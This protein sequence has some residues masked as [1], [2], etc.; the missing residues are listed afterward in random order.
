MMLRKLF[1]LLAVGLLAAA[2]A[3]RAVLTIDIT[4]GAEG[5]L[6]IAVVPFGW[7]SEAQTKPP[8]DVADI[9]RRDLYRSG[10]FAPLPVQSLPALPVVA[11]QINFD[12]WRMLGSR[13]L[14]IGRVEPA[15]ENKS[16]RIEFELYDVLKGERL[17][18]FT[19]STEAAGVRRTAHQI[20]D[21]IYQTLLGERG[22]FNTSI[23]YVTVGRKGNKR[24]YRLQVADADGAGAQTILTSDE[25]ILSSAWSPNAQSLAYVSFENKR[26][27]VYIQDIR[28]GKRR[29]VAAWSGL[30][31]APAWAPD[32]NRLALTLSKDGNPEI[33]I[34]NL[35]TRSLTRITD[36][37]AIDTEPSWAPDGQSLVFTSDRGGSPQIYQV[38]SR[39]GQARRVTFQGNYNARARYAP[40]GKSLALLN[41]SQGAYRIG[42]LSLVTKQMRILTQTSLD[43]S[44]DFAPNGGIIIYA[45]GPQLAAVSVDGRVR[46]RIA[47]AGGVEVRE[48]AW[49]PFL[50]K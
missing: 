3:A 7:P 6:P 46:Q 36:N 2:P 24:E 32:G 34:L 18:G 16:F 13:E 21:L 25:P 40:D 35:N 20:S 4:Q 48:P 5:A 28:T 8:A 50:V 43:E 45:S 1:A 10:R 33:Y 15:A 42:L 11:A 14:V 12:A 29:Q 31:S 38:S 26:T 9:V 39:G 17:T 19:F 23:A 49:S 22:V 47:V 27:A 44:P 41:G 37:P 30:N